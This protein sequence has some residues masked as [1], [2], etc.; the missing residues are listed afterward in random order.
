MKDAYG[1]ENERYIQ[2]SKAQNLLKCKKCGMDMI[3]SKRPTGIKWD[4]SGIYCYNSFF[5]TSD[6]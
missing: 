1:T 3:P 4:C 2:C 5:E 6:K